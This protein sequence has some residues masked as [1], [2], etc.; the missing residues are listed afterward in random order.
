MIGFISE[1]E[2]NY[3]NLSNIAFY[4]ELGTKQQEEV[5]KY[6]NWA[7]Y[8]VSFL[9]VTINIQK[10]CIRSKEQSQIQYHLLQQ[11]SKN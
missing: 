2:S 11:T 7:E 6:F 4:F 5:W 3:L 9:L 10:Q 8:T 1:N